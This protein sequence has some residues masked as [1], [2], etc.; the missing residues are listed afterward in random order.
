MVSIS[1]SGGACRTITTAPMRQMAL[2]S[3]P[4][5]PNSSLRKY[6]PK[7]A[8]ISTLSAPRGVTRIA[9]A[10]AYAAKLQTSPVATEYSISESNQFTRGRVSLTSRD[11]SPPKRVLEVHKSLSFESM[12]F[13]CLVQSLRGCQHRVRSNLPRDH[14]MVLKNRSELSKL[15]TFFVMTKLVPK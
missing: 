14:R 4:N 6:D 1:S 2:P 5:V 7:T 15:H 8:P 10:K 12:T 9:G 3:F 11:T 13:F